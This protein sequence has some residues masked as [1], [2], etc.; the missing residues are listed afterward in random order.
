MIRVEILCKR[1]GAHLGHMFEDGPEEKTG[2]RYCINS[3][4]L[5]FEKKD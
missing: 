4:C 1:C 3:A 5:K 2:L